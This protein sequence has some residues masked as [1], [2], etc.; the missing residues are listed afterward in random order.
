MNFIINPL[1]SCYLKSATDIFANSS[2]IFCLA[3]F[4]RRIFLF[5]FLSFRRLWKR[6][7]ALEIM[8]IDGIIGPTEQEVNRVGVMAFGLS[9]HILRL[10][11][12]HNCN[13]NK[14]CQFYFSRGDEL[15]LQGQTG[16]GE[17]WSGWSRCKGAFK[18]LFMEGICHPPNSKAR[19]WHPVS[20]HE[21]ETQFQKYEVQTHSPLRS[22][23][24]R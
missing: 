5:V 1:L 4:H 24:T 2:V 6:I 11:F 16:F 22:T 23:W 13:T 7:V 8:C 19:D 12:I 9:G 21:H 17:S 3:T 15:H 18:H 10:D 20:G 14:T